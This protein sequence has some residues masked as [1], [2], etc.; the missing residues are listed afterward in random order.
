MASLAPG[1][2]IIADQGV[3]DGTDG[4]GGQGLRCES[5]IKL[6]VDGNSLLSLKQCVYKGHGNHLDNDC[7]TY[8]YYLLDCFEMQPSRFSDLLH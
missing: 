3:V 5:S 2:R 4:A 6:L 8:V 1:V 7:Q